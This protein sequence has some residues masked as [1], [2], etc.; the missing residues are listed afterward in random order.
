MNYRRVYRQGNV[1]IIT[2]KWLAGEIAGHIINGKFISVREEV[3]RRNKLN[4]R[5]G[6]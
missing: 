3:E 1:I 4:N 2:D 6:L 5:L